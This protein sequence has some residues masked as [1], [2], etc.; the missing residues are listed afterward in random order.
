MRGPRCLEEVG[1]DGRGQVMLCML[2]QVQDRSVCLEGCRKDL[3]DLWQV[4]VRS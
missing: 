2:G 1:E 3:M 4:S